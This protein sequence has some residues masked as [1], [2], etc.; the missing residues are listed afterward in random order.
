VDQGLQLHPDHPILRTTLGYLRLREGR[1]KEAIEV[2]AAVIADEPSL[3]MAYPTLAMAHVLAGE[4]GR[5]EALVTARTL[6][7]A[8]CD[9]DTAYRVATYFAVAGDHDAALRWLRRAIY[10]GNENDP[11]F[12]T[13]PAWA[14]LRRSADFAAI[15]DSLHERH[16][17]NADLWRRL[18]R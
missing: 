10:L 7:A 11:W 14:P 8:R 5:A 9:P 1:A 13:N 3:Q 15:L 4:R 17:R 6:G 2:L 16:R 18:L 12:R